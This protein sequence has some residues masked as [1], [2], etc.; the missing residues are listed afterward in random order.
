[1]RD[2]YLMLLLR[3]NGLDAE[4]HGHK[5]SNNGQCKD[6]KDVSTTGMTRHCGDFFLPPCKEAFIVLVMPHPVTVVGISCAR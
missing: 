2:I 1:M 5:E 3:L 4:R 6:G